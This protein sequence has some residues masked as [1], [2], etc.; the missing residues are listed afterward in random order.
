MAAAGADLSDEQIEQLLAEAEAR[1][2]TAAQKSE[3]LAKQGGRAPRPPTSP[4]REAKAAQEPS[5]PATRGQ[6][7][8][9]RTPQLRQKQKK[10]NKVSG[11][12]LACRPSAL[13]MMKSISKQTMTHRDTPSWGTLLQLCDFYCS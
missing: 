1:L 4:T 3:S 9:L 13:R 7:L 5:R 10:T 6:D 2:S 8:V 12:F 11:A